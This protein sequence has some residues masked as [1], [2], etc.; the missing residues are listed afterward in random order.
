MAQT[1]T[2]LPHSDA[3]LVCQ[4]TGRPA[5]AE[6]RLGQG[7]AWCG[8]R[9]DGSLF[10]TVST[11]VHDGAYSDAELDRLLEDGKVVRYGTLDEGLLPAGE[12]GL[13]AATELFIIGAGQIEEAVD[14]G[15]SIS[16]A[17]NP[18]T[19]MLVGRPARAQGPDIVSLGRMWAL[20]EYARG[21]RPLVDLDPKEVAAQVFADLVKAER[22]G[23]GA[24]APGLRTLH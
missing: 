2:A 15:E 14:T 21:V 24:G 20:T 17:A 1:D 22:P 12:I 16:K 8:S 10:V 5:F 3:A 6:L 7:A 18:I 4:A 9:H 19:A 23:A 13:A 11:E